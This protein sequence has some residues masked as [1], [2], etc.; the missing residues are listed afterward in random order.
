MNP[1]MKAPEPIGFG[2]LLSFKDCV[3]QRR[4]KK[5]FRRSCVHFNMDS[6]WNF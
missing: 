2:K 6:V 4:P 1:G 5:G 3:I